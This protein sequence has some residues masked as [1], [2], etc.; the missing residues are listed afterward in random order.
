[1]IKILLTGANGQLGKSLSQFIKQNT[2]NKIKLYS[3]NSF[4]LD[5]RDTNFFF[6]CIKECSPDFILNCAAMTNVDFSEGNP[7]LSNEINAFSIQRIIEKIDNN[8]KLF[9][10]L[11][12]LI[13]IST[14]FVFDGVKGRYSSNSITNPINN[15]GK[16]K[17]LAEN[18][19]I[20]SN[21]NWYILRVGGLYSNISSNNFFSWVVN[22]LEQNKKIDVV[23]D[24]ISNPVSTFDLSHF[25]FNNVIIKKNSIKPK[26]I[27]HVGSEEEISRYDFALKIAKAN[28]LNL[29]NIKRISTKELMTKNPNLIA[30]RPY[31]SSLLIEDKGF[32]KYYIDD[33][34]NF[35]LQR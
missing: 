30:R 6:K 9:N 24:Q 10:I 7:E 18:I 13:Q 15:Y 17:E 20:N 35:I 1:M 26:S 4:E 3:Y 23:D 31:N 25:I 16:S 27:Y 12:C 11:P 14:D 8:K 22:S 5:I 21:L 32:K 33:S 19:I 28:N 2:L 29:S 34:I